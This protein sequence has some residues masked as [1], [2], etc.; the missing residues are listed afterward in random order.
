VGNP[1]VFVE[2][3]ASD[4][5]TARKFYGELF[6]WKIEDVPMGAN[7]YTTIGVGEG[8]GG[9]ISPNSDPG[10][11][12]HW[13]PYVQVNDVGAATEKARA[14]G[15]TVTREPTEVPPGWFSLIVDPSGA[16]LALWQPKPSS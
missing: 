5:A 8:T 3:Q 13:L 10:A 14:L 2:L 6:D 4:S 7:T 12:S 9:G 16:A 1:F 15:A 11:P